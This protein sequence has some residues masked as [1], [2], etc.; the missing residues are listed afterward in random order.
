MKKFTK[1]LALVTVVAILVCC[2]A[3]C[4]QTGSNTSATTAA[5]ADTD[6]VYKIGICQLVQ[7]DALDAATKG[8]KEALTAKLGDKVEFDEQ[9]ASGEKAN[10]ATIN[11]KFVADKV[12]LIMANAT[13]A[14]TTAANA[15]K[16]IPVVA[17][18][19]TDF[20][21]ALDMKLTDGKTGINVTGTSDLAPLDQQAQMIKELVPTAKTCGIIY[22]SAEPNSQ[23]QVDEITKYLKEIGITAKAYSFADTNDL[24]SVV[25]KAVSE[26]DVLYAPTDNTVASNAEAVYNIADPANKPLIAGESGIMKGCGVATLSIT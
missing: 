24:N 11:N 22:C 13:D 8:F 16:D 21:T 14:L 23:F 10:C 25:T 4:G 7:H 15:T 12:D 5:N 1:I 6:K 20:G 19:I 9:N 17:T 18:S 2:F 26:N 3:S